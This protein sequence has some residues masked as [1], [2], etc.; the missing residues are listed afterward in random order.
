M[1][2]GAYRE[3]DSLRVP[4]IVRWKAAKL[5]DEVHGPP[6]E[7]VRFYAATDIVTV[8]LVPSRSF[9][10]EDPHAV[11]SLDSVGGVR[12]MRFS[13]EVL[14]LYC[15]AGGEIRRHAWSTDGADGCRHFHI[16]L[17]EIPPSSA[18]PTITP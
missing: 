10:G 9:E 12:E 1:P 17:P 4:T 8:A 16:P 18:T 5:R 11:V 3:V 13:Q 15:P 6:S 7:P 2:A 14:E